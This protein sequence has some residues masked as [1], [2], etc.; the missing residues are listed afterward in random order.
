M[1]DEKLLAYVKKEAAKGISESQ[2]K[3]ELKAA[4]WNEKE[5]AA[6]IANSKNQLKETKKEEPKIVSETKVYVK[7]TKPLGF[8]AKI[9]RVIAKPKQFFSDIASE[10]IKNPI[11]FFSL[12]ICIVAVI[13]LIVSVVTIDYTMLGSI[14]F[15][16]SS[17]YVLLFLVITYAIFALYILITFGL[18]KLFKGNGTFN[19]STKALVYGTTPSML[20]AWIPYVQYGAWV[21]SIV[22]QGYG[23]AK[24]HELKWW[25]VVIILLIPLLLIVG[26]AILYLYYYPTV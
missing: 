17:L 5:V 6:A 13:A 22:L 26:I 19:D 18:V 20:L 4:G 12:L 15:L 9:W 21:W 16:Y 11:K 3:K 14:E 2:I 8:F 25:K 10:P 7:E 1:V 23:L 24:L